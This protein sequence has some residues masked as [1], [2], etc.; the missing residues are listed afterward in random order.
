MGV[1]YLR[2]LV[3]VFGIA[4]PT[5]SEM[6]E[7][8]WQDE[9]L[10][11]ETQINIATEEALTAAFALIRLQKEIFDDVVSGVHEIGIEVGIKDEYKERLSM[12]VKRIRASIQV[13]EESWLSLIHI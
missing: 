10:S 1:N 13:A 12:L 9:T 6:T 11:P 5:R 2:R 4:Q 7:L 3:I 8:G